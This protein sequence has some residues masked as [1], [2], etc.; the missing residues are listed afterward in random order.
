LPPPSSRENANLV[1]DGSIRIGAWSQSL[2]E[3]VTRFSAS[4]VTVN[5]G[6]SSTVKRSQHPK[7]ASDR[8]ECPGRKLWIRPEAFPEDIFAGQMCGWSGA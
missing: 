3:S 5:M 7:W 2:R 6:M 4:L 8:R 1:D